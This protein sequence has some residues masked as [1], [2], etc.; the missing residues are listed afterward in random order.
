MTTSTITNAAQT[1][2]N[3]F[4]KTEIKYSLGFERM[5]KLSRKQTLNAFTALFFEGFTTIPANNEELKTRLS[6]MT[7]Q[8]FQ[9]F[10][11]NNK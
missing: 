1:L 6:K 5:M 4:P 2:T 7:E 11:N 3:L 8:E 9:S 10:K